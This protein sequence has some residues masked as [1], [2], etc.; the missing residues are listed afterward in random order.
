MLPWAQHEYLRLCFVYRKGESNTC[1]TAI[2]VHKSASKSIE[3][4]TE[5]LAYTIHVLFAVRD[6]VSEWVCVLYARSRVYACGDRPDGWLCVCATVCCVSV[7]YSSHSPSR[8]VS[9]EPSL[10]LEWDHA[11]HLKPISSVSENDTD[12]CVIFL[13]ENR[14]V[15]ACV[16]V[17]NIKTYSINSAQ[18]AIELN[19]RPTHNIWISFS[20]HRLKIQTFLNGDRFDAVNLLHSFFFVWAPSLARVWK[21]IEKTAYTNILNMY[22]YYG[23]LFALAASLT[24][25]QSKGDIHNTLILICIRRNLRLTATMV[26]RTDFNCGLWT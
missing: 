6:R 1:V 22:L 17:L 7:A 12:L 13:G 21:Y 16:Y 15:C 20:V 26:R 10:C 19:G 2:H 8:S 5:S 14:A 24:T 18:C 3:Y 4:N 9:Y 25:V 23:L 11:V